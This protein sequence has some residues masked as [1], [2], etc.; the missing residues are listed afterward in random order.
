MICKSRLHGRCLAQSRWKA[1]VGSTRVQQSPSLVTDKPKFMKVMLLNGKQGDWN[2]LASWNAPAMLRPQQRMRE[3]TIYFFQCCLQT[4]I[5]GWQPVI[6]DKRS[7]F[8]S[9]CTKWGAKQRNHQ[10]HTSW[11]SRGQI[12]QHTDNT[13]RTDWEH[14]WGLATTQQGIF[15]RWLPWETHTACTMFMDGGGGKLEN[16]PTCHFFTIRILKKIKDK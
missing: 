15:E 3:I 7:F 4:L 1:H 11:Y 8:S 10:A 12:S 16:D 9:L 6:W 2:L 14:G 5:S 13:Q